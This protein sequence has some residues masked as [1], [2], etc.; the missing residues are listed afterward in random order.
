MSA[1]VFFESASELATLTNTF[2]VSLTP[3]DPTT[4][5]LTVTTP[6]GT[7]T[8]YTYAATQITK[9]GTGVYTKDITCT[10]AGIW[11]YEWV[12][13]GTAT[14]TVAG[15][16]T[17]FDTELQRNY[18]TVEELKSR[19]GISDTNDDFELR[20]AVD[21]ASRWIDTYTGRTFYRLAE[22]RTFVPYEPWCL[23]VGDLVSLTTLKTDM[24][25]DGTFEVTWSASDYEL[26]PVNPNA[27]PQQWPYTTIVA[28]GQTHYF[29]V[30]Y[31]SPS[32]QHL[33]QVAGV[34]GWP[35][36]PAAVKQAALALATDHLKLKGAAFGIAGSSEYGP[37]RVGTNSAARAMLDRYRLVGV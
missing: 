5:S 1:T 36:V 7:A 34:W 19:L 4:V 35:A 18:C 29:P 14:D 32:R 2:S 30:P 31:R 9:S 20:L 28:V 24:D 22:T 21:S 17:V 11:Q 10:E 37:L 26:N 12:G 3:T 8:T 25:A 23:E 33:V 6:S 16:W 13:T 15:T 27:G